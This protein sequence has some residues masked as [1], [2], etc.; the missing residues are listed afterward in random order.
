M[1]TLLYTHLMRK[2][3]A[4]WQMISVKYFSATQVIAMYT[5]YKKLPNYLWVFM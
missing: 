3:Q 2:M 5:H 1:F 4:K